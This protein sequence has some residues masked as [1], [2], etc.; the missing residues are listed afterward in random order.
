[1]YSGFGVILSKV[2]GVD[3]ELN[4]LAAGAATGMLFKSSSGLRQCAIGGGTGLAIAAAYCLL[5]SRDR[6][7]QMMGL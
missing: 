7:R 1:M 5:T 2:R 4:T 3:D 6:V